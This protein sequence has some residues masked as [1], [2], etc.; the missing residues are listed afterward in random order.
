MPSIGFGIAVIT[1]VGLNVGK[2]DYKKAK[3]AEKA[4]FNC[5]FYAVF[6]MG[7]FAI[8]FLVMP[9]ILV[10]FFV[11]NYEK[12]VAYLAGRC[13]FIGAIEQPF[14]GI[15]IVFEGALKGIGD[16][17]SPFFICCFTSWIIRLPLT[18]YFI[19][20]LKYPV[21]AVWCIIAL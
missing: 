9:N 1:L 2:K 6:I 7:I 8:I 17:K 5:V 12:R 14:I 18:Y 21:T 20:I 15:S 16:V 3:K 4:A 11:N 19:N 10:N 13:L